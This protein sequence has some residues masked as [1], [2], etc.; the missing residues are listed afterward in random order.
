MTDQKPQY[1]EIVG[2]Y[3]SI[4]SQSPIVPY[5]EHTSLKGILGNLKDKKALDVAC[6]ANINPNKSPSFI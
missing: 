1:D 3:D 6:G 4:H 5:V 2:E